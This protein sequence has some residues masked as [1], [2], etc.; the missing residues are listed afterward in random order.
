MAMDWKRTNTL[1]PLHRT[2]PRPRDIR[3]FT[4]LEL[5]I[6]V[7]V[8][9]LVTTLAIPVF[10]QMYQ[11]NR[12]RGVRDD[13]FRSL[14]YARSEAIT[15]NQQVSV[16]PKR[17]NRLDCRGNVNNTRNWNEGWLVWADGNDD[18]AFQTD[19][20]LRMVDAIDDYA[21][22][23][24]SGTFNDTSLDFQPDGSADNTTFS[25]CAKGHRVR[26]QVVV[27]R[28]GRVRNGTE[29]FDDIDCNSP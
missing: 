5:M 29:D 7:A 14:N 23:R 17:P 15:R 1:L 16:C 24:T 19:E 27:S 21:K 25:V 2:G 22:I 18:G 8:L 9:A 10:D 28:T 26:L 4:L 6:T 13:L 3:G 12:V 11:T 20:L